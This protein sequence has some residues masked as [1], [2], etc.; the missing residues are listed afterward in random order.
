MI[1]IRLIRI[2][3]MEC[4]YRIWDVNVNV[5]MTASERWIRGG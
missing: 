2:E 5:K 4:E 3:N 1:S